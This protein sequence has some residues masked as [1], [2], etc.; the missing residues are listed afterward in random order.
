[1][2]HKKKTKKY[3]KKNAL[4]GWNDMVVWKNFRLSY[5]LEDT[6]AEHIQHSQSGVGNQSRQIHG[7]VSTHT[8]GFVPF[9]LNVKQMVRLILITSIFN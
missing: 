2:R 3:D 8:G 9:V 6:W 4:P 1:M 5:I 7:F